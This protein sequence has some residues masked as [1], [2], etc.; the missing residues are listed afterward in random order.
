[1][2]GTS[3]PSLRGWKSLS[4]KLAGRAFAH[5]DWS[6]ISCGS[7]VPITVSIRLA[8]RSCFIEMA[9]WSVIFPFGFGSLNS[10]FDLAR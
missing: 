4:K 9:L 10:G 6:M 5:V 3:L 7:H 2:I 1:M 8:A